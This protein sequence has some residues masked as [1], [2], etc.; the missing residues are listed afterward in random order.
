MKMSLPFTRFRNLLEKAKMD[1]KPHQIQGI[2]WCIKRET[3]GNGGIIADEMGLGKTITMIGLFVSN[4][5]PRTLI[6]LPIT[7]LE[8]W[9]AQIYR[10][11][12]HN[13]LIYHGSNIR[14]NSLSNN[15]NLRKAP[16]VLTTY[17]VVSRQYSI[18]GTASAKQNTDLLKLFWNRIVFDE[19]HHL[20][21]ARTQKHLGADI[22]KCK[23][24]WFITGTPIQNHQRDFVSLCNLLRMNPEEVQQKCILR[25]TKKQVGIEIPD[26]V[27]E[28]ISVSWSNEGE[29]QL[30]QEIHSLLSFSGTPSPSQGLLAEYLIGTSN[31]NNTNN[32][33]LQNQNNIDKSR[34]IRALL[35]AKQCCTYPHL[36]KNHI[37]RLLNHHLI[38]NHHPFTNGIKSKSKMDVV[39]D[40]IVARKDNQCGKIVFCQFRGE[41]D[42]MKQRLTDAGMCVGVLDGRTTKTEKFEILNQNSEHY[43]YN[44]LILQ[45]QTCSEG[46]NLQERFSEVYFASPHWNP[47]LEDQ[48]I[49][50]C[51]RIGQTKVVNV[52]RF[53]MDGFDIN[54]N[55]LSRNDDDFIQSAEKEKEKEKENENEKE[56]EKDSISIDGYVNIVQQN[57]REM[58]QELGL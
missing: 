9:Q 18:R 1:T 46:L 37:D 49:A 22:L 30:A 20:R 31:T 41:I 45:I 56:Q 11:T 16:I 5:V 17:G 13:A 36:L 28:S 29:K 24:R 27:D 34:T 57:K 26:C 43:K 12:G 19:A 15:D 58:M 55:M 25:R 7:L 42:E 47:S 48:A 32:K 38:D 23:H 33:N 3:E 35:L 21:N 51:H 14:L 8:Q 6:V 50:R 2:E 39:V 4:F 44:V 54:I 10:V 53:V 52:Y 40:N